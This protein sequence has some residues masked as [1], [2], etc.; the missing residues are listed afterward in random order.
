[1]PPLTSTELTS[2]ELA[3][4]ELRKE[5]QKNQDFMSRMRDQSLEEGSKEFMD[6][7]AQEQIVRWHKEQAKKK[8]KETGERSQEIEDQSRNL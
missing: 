8:A 6:K 1:M 3:R 2:T 7:I 4:K 5:L